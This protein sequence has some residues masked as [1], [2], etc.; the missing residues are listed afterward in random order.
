MRCLIEAVTTPFMRL[1][2]NQIINLRAELQREFVKRRKSNRSYSLRAYAKYLDVDQSLLSKLMNGQRTISTT[3]AEKIT[4]KLKIKPSEA[5]GFFYPFNT[6]ES[7]Q[8]QQMADDQVS[9]LAEWSHF[10][11]LELIKTKNF[12]MDI[13]WISDRLDLH[14]T[15][16]Q[17]SIERLLRMGYLKI[18]KNKV[19]LLKPNNN[20]TNTAATTVARQELQKSLLAKAQVAVE[21]V[22]FQKRDHGSLTVAVRKDRVLEFKEKLQKIRDELDAYFQPS[23]DDGKYDEVYQLTVSFFPLTKETKK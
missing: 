3:I 10:A 1:T 21:D 15:E 19:V 23:A 18:E 8:Y 20:W 2:K 14:P 12:K 7:I 5:A 22:E 11:I 9:V 6:S 17:E 13:K 16:I 4:P